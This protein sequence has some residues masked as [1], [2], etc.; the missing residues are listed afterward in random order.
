M[1][2]RPLW[3]PDKRALPNEFYEE[4]HDYTDEENKERDRIRKEGDIL[5]IDEEWY[6]PSSK[7]SKALLVYDKG[8]HKILEFPLCP[9]DENSC[10]LG[11]YADNIKLGA[12]LIEGYAVPYLV[13]DWAISPQKDELWIRC[14]QNLDIN[15]CEHVCITYQDGYYM[16]FIDTFYPYYEMD[17]DGNQNFYWPWNNK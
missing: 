16:H 13:I 8:H 7:N 11:V 5:I 3:A 12:N 10:P 2:D 17:N 14:K 6:I 4:L 15:A 9:T 1:N